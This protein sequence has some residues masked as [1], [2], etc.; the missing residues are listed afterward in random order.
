MFFEIACAIWAIGDGFEAAAATIQLKYHWSQ[1]SYFGITSSA[2]MFLF[3]TLSYSGLSHHVNR[4]VLVS[5]LIIPVVTIFMAFTNH[6]HHLLWSNI[7]IV[8]GTTNGVYYYGPWFW[9]NVAFQ[10]T[11]T[12]VS[13]IILISGAFKV[14][15]L[16]K[17]QF[18]I[19]LPGAILPIVASVLYIFKLMPLKGMDPTPIAFIT[20]GLVIAVSLYWFG[21]FNIM[22][23]ARKQAIDNLSDGMLIIDLEGRIMDCNPV[24]CSSLELVRGEVVNKNIQDVFSF[25]G[26]NIDDFCLENG[27]TIEYTRGKIENQLSFELKCHKVLDKNK[28]TIGRILMLYD[29]TTK[30]MILDAL[31]DSNARREKEIIE[32]EKL[33]RDL[34]AYARSVAHDLK[35]PIGAVMNLSE[36]IVDSLNKKDYNQAGEMSA[37]LQDQSEKMVK[38]IDALLLLSGIRNEVVEYSQVNLNVVIVDVIGRIKPEISKYNAVVE[39]QEDLG[40]VTG[41]EPWIEEV[42]VNILS[43]GIKY[44]GRPPVV[45]VGSDR[46]D[47]GRIKT[48]VQDNGNGIPSDSFEKVFNDFERL[49]RTDIP[50]SGLGLPIV[51]RIIEKLGGEVSIESTGK[52]G[53]GCRFSFTL[54]AASRVSDL[55]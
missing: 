24:F 19:L 41:Y 55:P 29:I 17:I 18:W 54:R 6:L 11:A 27:Q 46:L 15:S 25:L 35:N 13:I 37:M 8:E 43:N 3:F 20:S 50:G 40:K 22:P 47:D 23:I 52:H 31:A 39:I 44:G 48:W 12:A 21:M 42:L 45:K 34:D 14:F 16:Y 30:K 2:L 7:V 28:N 26:I 1:V 49:K 33:I 38:I 53:E 4:K 9:V 5:L 36:L 51:K 10:Y 32:K